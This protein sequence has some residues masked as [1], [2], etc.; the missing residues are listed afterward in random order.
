MSTTP[1]PDLDPLF[2]TDDPFNPPLSPLPTELP[3]DGPEIGPPGD[4]LPDNVDLLPNEGGEEDDFPTQPEPDQFPD[5][6]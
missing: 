3:P 4:E 5:V 2:T 6:L 1:N